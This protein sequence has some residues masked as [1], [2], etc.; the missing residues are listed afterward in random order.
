MCGLEKGLG[1]ENKVISGI[2]YQSGTPALACG[3]QSHYNE[4]IAS[5]YQARNDEVI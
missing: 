3:E 2:S 1:A 5:P 4:E